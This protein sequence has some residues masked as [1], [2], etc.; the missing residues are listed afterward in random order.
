MDLFPE[1]ENFLKFGQID[2]KVSGS[3]ARLSADKC[4]LVLPG[5]AGEN[6]VKECTRIC[7]AERCDGVNVVPLRKP[8]GVRF[9]YNPTLPQQCNLQA[10]LRQAGSKAD[11]AKV[12]FPLKSVVPK[13]PLFLTCKSVFIPPPSFLL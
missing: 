11:S 10:L 8:K 4:K 3:R 5:A 2:E 12:C 9:A 7:E 13:A 1:N 6:A